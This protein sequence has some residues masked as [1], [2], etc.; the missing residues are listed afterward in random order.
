MHT[1][2]KAGRVPKPK[3]S[4]PMNIGASHVF[5]ALPKTAAYPRA[6]ASGKGS[7]NATE[8]TAPKLAPMLNKGVTSPPTN[9][10][11]RVKIVKTNFKIR[12]AR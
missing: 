1:T 2:K 8:A 6:A 4:Q 5:V 11:E 12:D 10:A 7:P 3:I 9:P